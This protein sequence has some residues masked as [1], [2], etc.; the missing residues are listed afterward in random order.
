MRKNFNGGGHEVFL[1]GGVQTPGEQT[2][3][4]GGENNG[5]KTGGLSKFV[6]PPLCV[7]GSLLKTSKIFQVKFGL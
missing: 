7:Y 3:G 1:G 4:K 5:S 2:S 6:P